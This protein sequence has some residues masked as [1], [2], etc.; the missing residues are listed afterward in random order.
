LNSRS[1]HLSVSRARCRCSIKRSW[2]DR[3]AP[4]IQY[5]LPPRELFS[6]FVSSNIIKTVRRHG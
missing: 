4:H 5:D 2:D 3:P 1:G 6:S